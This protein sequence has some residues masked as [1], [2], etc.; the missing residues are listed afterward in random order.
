MREDV[1]YKH[2]EPRR[3]PGEKLRHLLLSM[4]ALQSMRDAPRS[5]KSRLTEAE[6]IKA[7]Q[8]ILIVE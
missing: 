2:G 8:E 3:A 4:M 5:H 7:R 1:I 6:R